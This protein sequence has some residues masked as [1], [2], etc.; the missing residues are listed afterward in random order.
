MEAAAAGVPLIALPFVADQPANAL[1]IEQRGWGLRLP[2]QKVGLNGETNVPAT[3][4]GTLS[5]VEV[6]KLKVLEDPSF[7]QVAQGIQAASSQPGGTLKVASA[8]ESWAVN[9]PTYAP[10]DTEELAGAELS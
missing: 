4:T 8:I 3:Y 1:L 7:R 2:Q 6:R 10:K 9:P 5:A